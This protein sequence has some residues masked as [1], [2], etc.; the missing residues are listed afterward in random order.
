MSRKPSHHTLHN[1]IPKLTETHDLHRL[2]DVHPGFPRKQFAKE[3]WY[4]LL[5]Q[6]F[7][8]AFGTVILYYCAC[9]MLNE[10]FVRRRGLAYGLM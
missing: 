8:Y 10:C 5:S 2:V 7:L 3:L 6:G 4:L 1:Q 9:S